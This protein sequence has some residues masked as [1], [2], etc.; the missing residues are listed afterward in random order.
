MVGYLQKGQSRNLRK[1]IVT[2]KSEA[3]ENLKTEIDNRNIEKNTLIVTK[4]K[5]EYPKMI[6]TLEQLTDIRIINDILSIY[7]AY[8]L[9]VFDRPEQLEIP[10][11][12]LGLKEL[13]KKYCDVTFLVIVQEN[14]KN[15]DRKA[16]LSEE[17]A[18]FS[19]I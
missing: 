15:K 18:F 4:N 11:F 5:H 2:E 9:V 12:E 10:A 16:I 17:N 7:P 3:V 6:R 8:K 1:L 19:I 13:T 14:K